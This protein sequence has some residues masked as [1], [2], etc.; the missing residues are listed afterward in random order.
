MKDLYSISG[1]LPAQFRTDPASN[2]IGWTTVNPEQERVIIIEGPSDDPEE[3]N[4]VSGDS[5]TRKSSDYSEIKVGDFVQVSL[6]YQGTFGGIRGGIYSVKETECGI[7]KLSEKLNR[8]WIE[9]NPYIKKVDLKR[10]TRVKT[11]GAVVPTGRE[12]PVEGSGVIIDIAHFL[13]TTMP[14][15]AKIKD[16]DVIAWF[17][18]GTL[19]LDE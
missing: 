13:E 16:A 12:T 1:L 10:G 9:K 6:D 15:M 17:S 5:Y 11:I 19:T 2:G 8:P 3:L 14:Y 18:E 7:L 4:E